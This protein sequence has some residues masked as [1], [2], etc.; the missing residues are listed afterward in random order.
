MVLVT[1][2]ALAVALGSYQLGLVLN[3]MIEGLMGE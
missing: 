1:G 2:A 3:R